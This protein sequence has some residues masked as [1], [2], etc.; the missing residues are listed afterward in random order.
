MKESLLSAELSGE[1]LAKAALTP[2]LIDM[3]QAAGAVPIVVPARVVHDGVEADSDDVCACEL[4]LADL[5]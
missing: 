2:V 3:K 1:V 4:R 5:G